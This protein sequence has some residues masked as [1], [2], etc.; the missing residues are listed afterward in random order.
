M[1]TTIFYDVIVVLSGDVVNTIFFITL[2]IF[3]KVLP[4]D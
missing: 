2:M 1:F 4:M 3:V